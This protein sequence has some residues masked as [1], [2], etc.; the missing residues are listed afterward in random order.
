MLRRQGVQVTVSGRHDRAGG[1]GSC[2]VPACE[3]EKDVVVRRNDQLEAGGVTFRLDCNVG[4]DISFDE[5]AR[6]T[7]RC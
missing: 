7:T 2:R 1:L 3:L 4:A 6:A 5:S